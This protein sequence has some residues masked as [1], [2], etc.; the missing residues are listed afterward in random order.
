MN[1]SNHSSIS[2]KMRLKEF[3]CE[4]KEVEE[5]LTV[6]TDTFLAVFPSQNYTHSPLF[7]Y[8]FSILTD[9]YPDTV[10]LIAGPDEEGTL[11]AMKSILGSK[12]SVG[13]TVFTGMLTGRDKLAALSCADVFVLP[14][15]S[16]GF[17]IAILEAMA[18]RLPV[19]IS[20]GCDFPEVAEHG[21]G[22]VVKAGDVE[23]TQALRELASDAE[24]RF[25]MGERGRKLVTERY[26]WQAAASTLAQLY[27]SLAA[28]ERAKVPG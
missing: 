2:V 23:V 13:K 4:F 18:S 21:A 28:P 7:I 1:T 24:L 25:R 20:D 16:E 10:L 8:H 19:V 3:H 22:L 9:Q 27:R 14:S 15:Y 17:S 12:G 11:Q 6:S 5:F 26:T